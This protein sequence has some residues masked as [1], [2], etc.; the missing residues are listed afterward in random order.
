MKPLISFKYTR[1]RVGSIAPNF[2]KSELIENLMLS[3][4]PLSGSIIGDCND[5][6]IPT[7][8]QRYAS[9]I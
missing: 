8:L 6:I 5:S 3:D 4:R 2:L 7:F 1:K 9:K